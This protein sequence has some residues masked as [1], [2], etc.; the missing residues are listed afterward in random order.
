[1]L[2]LRER[3][4]VKIDFESATAQL[5][6]TILGNDNHDL[7]ETLRTIASDIGLSHI[8]YL[9]LSP[10]KSPDICLLVAVVTYSRL[11]QH[12]YFVKKY[13]STDPVIF[14]GREADQ[15]FDWTNLPVDDPAT[16]AF[17]TDAL[18]HNVGRN[19][20]SIPLR[21]RRGVFALVSFTSELSTDEW[22]D[23]KST[24]MRSLKLL[25]VLI[26]SASNINFKLPAFPVHL[27][28]REEQCLLWAAR[29]KTYQ[30][31]A[32]ILGLA[33]GSVKT[34]LDAARHKLHCMNLTHAAAVAFATGVIPA[35]ALK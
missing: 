5:T 29:G 27:S 34:H 9:R 17:F 22:E 30:E 25:T 21:N 14:Y 31:I 1:M 24:Y 19:G 11:W 13:M 35:Q 2:S 32:E 10:D 8:A 3:V 4:E 16:K 12:R 23:Y 20:L 28:N 7:A 6:E 15:P 33:F 18:N 26:D